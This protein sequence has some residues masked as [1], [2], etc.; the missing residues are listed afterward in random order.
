VYLLVKHST[1][2]STSTYYPRID[3]SKSRDQQEENIRDELR[4]TFSRVGSSSAERQGESAILT[5][6]MSAVLIDHTLEPE[7]TA[8][9]VRFLRRRAG[10]REG[11][12]NASSSG[13]TSCF[14]LE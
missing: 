5:P 10:G 14:P 13:L 8:K 7:E 4:R 1:D 3:R 2:M 11:E 12:E 6:S 9:G